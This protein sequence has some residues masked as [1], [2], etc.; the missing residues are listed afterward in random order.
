M[1]LAASE[2]AARPII[3]VAVAA[4][5]TARGSL[6]SSTAAVVALSCGLTIEPISPPSC[7]IDR[8]SGRVSVFVR[9]DAMPKRKLD[10]FVC[11]RVILFPAV[12]LSIGV[13]NA[14]VSVFDVANSASPNTRTDSVVID[15]VRGDRMAIFALLFR[16]RRGTCR[17]LENAPIGLSIEIQSIII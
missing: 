2:M 11:N 4:T 13:T 8:S 1:A 6:V 7:S 17:K 5:E 14:H 15:T 16:Y 9:R 12:V 3:L 10:G